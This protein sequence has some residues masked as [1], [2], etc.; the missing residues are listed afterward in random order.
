[1][2]PLLVLLPLANITALSYSQPL[3]LSYVNDT[4]VF[5]SIGGE[6]KVVPPVVNAPPHILPMVENLG[7]EIGE[8]DDSVV[9]T[10][11]EPEEKVRAVVLSPP[12]GAT[13]IT[14]EAEIIWIK[15]PLKLKN[16]KVVARYALPEKGE[17]IAR[18]DNGKPAAIKIKNRIYVGFD[19]TRETLANLLFLYALRREDIA[20]VLAL[21]A[22]AAGVGIT[23]SQLHSNRDKI[24]K[25]LY[26]GLGS[27]ALRIK[28]AD[29]EEVLSHDLRREI[30]NHILDNPDVHL[31]EIKRTFKISMSTALW[32]LRV[33]ERAGLIKSKKVGNRLMY[34]PAYY[35]PEEALVMLT[36]KN[37]KAKMIVDMLADVG[38]AHLRR[39]AR[40]LGI[41]PETVRYNLRKLERAGVVVSRVRGNRIEYSLSPAVV[42]K[43]YYKV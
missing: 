12:P 32:H 17:I 23:L 27:V 20:G 40:E 16:S 33:L 5:S 11:R 6:F 1:M 35:H 18:F 3:Y 21:T 19:L 22:G 24:I 8:G 30:M 31:R 37:E 34:F 2:L 41:N 38:Y 39:I 13:P 25:T 14:G 15:D 10:D 29:E 4:P 36:L 43:M 26:S 42:Q 28:Y 7:F 9:I